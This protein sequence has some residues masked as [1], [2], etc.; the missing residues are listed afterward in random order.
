MKQWLFVASD[1]VERDDKWD[2]VK[3][4]IITDGVNIAFVTNS[5]KNYTDRP[6]NDNK[7]LDFESINV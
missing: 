3:N 5:S 2:F 4:T 7:F 6:V 1:T